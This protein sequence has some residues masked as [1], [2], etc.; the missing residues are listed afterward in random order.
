MQIEKEKAKSSPVKH[1]H[2]DHS[3]DLN[4]LRRIRGQVEGIENMVVD[5]RYCPEILIQ[6]KATVSALRSVETSIMKRHMSHC[7]TD[8]IKS[9][10]KKNISEKFDEIIHMFERGS[11][12]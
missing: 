7:L 6:I 2:A 8:A 4:R 11:N 5:G 12:F 1:K 3:S 10:N 9:G